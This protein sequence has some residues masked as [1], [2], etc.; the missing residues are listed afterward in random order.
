MCIAIYKP[1]GT[2]PLWEKY[3]NGHDGNPHGWGFAVVN[4]G[5]LVVQHGYD[6]NPDKSW[7]KFRRAF[8]RFGGNQAIIHF[9]WATHGNKEAANCHPYMVSD[10]L[11]MIHNGVISIDCDIDKTKSD[12]WHYVQHVVKP[13]HR[14]NPNFFLAAHH[15]YLQKKAH[16]SSK[17]AFLRADGAYGIWNEDAGGWDAGHWWSNNGYNTPIKRAVTTTAK[18]YSGKGYSTSGGNPY[19]SMG[20]QSSCYKREKLLDAKDTSTPQLSLSYVGDAFDDDTVIEVDYE[21]DGTAVAYASTTAVAVSSV[22]SKP[23]TDKLVVAKPSRI[24]TALPVT[25]AMGCREDFSTMEER[26]EELNKNWQLAEKVKAGLLHDGVDEIT[27]DDLEETY[28]M[29]GLIAIGQVCGIGDLTR[30]RIS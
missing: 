16:Y 20:Y 5:R 30:E 13:L 15:S 3:K 4:K 24:V 12:T 2:K 8:G 22:H 17:F 18:W 9:R 29:D 28:G 11:A 7:R 25:T 23:V 6:A 10:S 19:G 27:I 21:D 1:H 26:Y 14:E